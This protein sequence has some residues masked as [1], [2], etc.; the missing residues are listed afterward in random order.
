MKRL[1]MKFY[2]WL[3]F[4]LRRNPIYRPVK[5]EWLHHLMWKNVPK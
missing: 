1:K 2:R 5:H 4:Y 3:C